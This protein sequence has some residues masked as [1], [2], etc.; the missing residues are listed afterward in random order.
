MDMQTACQAP[1]AGIGLSRPNCR[2]NC[3]CCGATLFI[4]E[5]AA[6]S[7]TGRIQHTWSCDDCG[8]EFVTSISVFS[9]RT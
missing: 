4:A 7:F 5:Q 2:P 1:I 6:F 9:R 8:N 3:P